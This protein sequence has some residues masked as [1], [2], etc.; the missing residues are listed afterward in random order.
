MRRSSAA[1]LL[2]LAGCGS[3]ADRKAQSSEAV[4]KIAVYADGRITVNGAPS[5]LQAVSQALPRLKANG[6]MVWYYREAPAADPH[7][8]AMEVIRAVAG[9]QVPIWM[10]T[11]PDFSEGRLASPK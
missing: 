10:S 9:A 2:L 11:R 5:T 1:L 3:P 4:M 8:V 7:P 6:G